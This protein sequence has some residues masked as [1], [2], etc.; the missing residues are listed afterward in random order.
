LTIHV[1]GLVQAT[2]ESR[3]LWSERLRRLP[4]Q[5]TDYWHRRL[6]RA[7]HERPRSRAGERG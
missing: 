2:A 7:R 1:T 5:E 3:H 4:I 6:L